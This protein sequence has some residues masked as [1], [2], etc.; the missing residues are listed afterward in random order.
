MTEETYATVKASYL[1]K[2]SVY[3]LA[4]S[5]AKQLEFNPGGDLVAALKKLGGSVEYKNFWDPTETDDGS[6][7]IE[8]EGK[9]LIYLATD[10]SVERDRFTLAH[11]LGHYVL[12]Y[13]WPKSRGDE[14]G[15]CKASRYGSDRAEWE[16]NW[17]AAAFLMPHK[18]FAAEYG[19]TSGNI[20][21]IAEYF[22]VSQA[23]AKVRASA[24]NLI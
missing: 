5:V 21:S 20:R 4:E 22:G 14:L 24:L 1:T 18:E 17:F 7:F 12:H 13:L 11:E 23:A 2:K 19:E 3:G 8:D 6:I 10:T 9:F 16:A 15:K